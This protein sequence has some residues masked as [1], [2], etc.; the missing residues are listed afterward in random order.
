MT[1]TGFCSYV[2]AA[3]RIW[4]GW[5]RWRHSRSQCRGRRCCLLH[6]G[7]IR[8]AY[9]SYTVHKQVLLRE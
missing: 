4:P 2:L 5:E 6:R 1:E 8:N 3:E 9:F 7:D